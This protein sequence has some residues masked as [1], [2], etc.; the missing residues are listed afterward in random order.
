[1]QLPQLRP[2]LPGVTVSQYENGFDDGYMAV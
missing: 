2:L 1:M